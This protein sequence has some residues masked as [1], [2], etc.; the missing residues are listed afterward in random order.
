MGNRTDDMLLLQEKFAQSTA[1]PTHAELVPLASMK[2]TKQHSCVS[3]DSGTAVVASKEGLVRLAT[4]SARMS[5]VVV[6]LIPTSSVS[7]FLFP[8]GQ[9]Y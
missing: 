1:P 2:L 7:S 3:T 9:F 8:Y 6:N 4:A 5:R